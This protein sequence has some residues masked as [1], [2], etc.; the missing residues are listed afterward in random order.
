[1][2]GG[3]YRT[4]I[5]PNGDDSTKALA[6]YANK[7]GKAKSGDTAKTIA[8]ASG[9]GDTWVP[10]IAAMAVFG[11]TQTKAPQDPTGSRY[12][13]NNNV[14][15]APVSFFYGGA[16]TDHIGAFAQFTYNDAAYGA[17]DGSD[18]YASKLWTQDNIDLRYANTG[19]VGGYDV[20]YGLTAN[21]NP[22]VQDPWNTT[23]AWSFPFASSSIAPSP[24]ASTLIDGGF[25]AHVGSLGVYANIDD[26]VYVELSGYRTLSAKTQANLQ[27]DPFGAAGLFDGVAPY[28]RVALEPH[29]GDNWLEFGTF[30]MSARVH[31]WTFV[32]DANGIYTADTYLQSDRY[33]D[34][35]FDSQY[36]YQG[37][38][39]W[40]TLRGSYIR[41][42]QTLDASF[43]S[44]AS[45]NPTNQLNS[46]KLLASL[47]Y[48]NDNRFVLTG[49][50]FDT[51]GS[52]DTGLYGSN[53]SG[54]SP[55]SNGYVGEIAY[56]PFINSQSPGWPWANAR[57]G[58]QYTYYNKF[59]GTALNAQ[60][61]NTVF[62][63][64][65]LAM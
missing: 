41:E 51:W 29:W 37:D 4:T 57:I 15:A 44:G 33:T 50:Y 43:A 5:F 9:T 52:D 35:G 10:P 63:H 12:N 17:L 59:D 53:A 6:D 26:L 58:L 46:L 24:G 21:N 11:Y 45:A 40:I 56:I 22:T 49:Q 38:N 39:Y 13:G 23:P 32:T 19:K 30:G 48:G 47:A 61:N 7:D 28:W 25:A 14:A 36:Q 31:P 65:W 27:T 54:I 18:P 62:L 60:D 16:I 55:N 64:A 3:N 20:T 1:M 42:Q 34:V 2:G 8:G